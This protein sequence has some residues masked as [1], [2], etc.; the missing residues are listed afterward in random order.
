MN[1]IALMCVRAITP[2]WL[3]VVSAQAQPF[4][5]APAFQPTTS[6]VLGWTNEG[7][8][9]AIAHANPQAPHCYRDGL[10]MVATK[11]TRD[12]GIP[13]L[14]GTERQSDITYRCPK[15]GQTARLQR[16]NWVTEAVSSLL[17]SN[18]PV[19]KPRPVVPAVAPKVGSIRP[20]L[21]KPEAATIQRT[22]R[23]S[24]KAI[25]PPPPPPQPPDAPPIPPD[26]PAPAS[27]TNA[28]FSLTWLTFDPFTNTT[29][30]R[31]YV[32]PI[33][34]TRYLVEP[35]Q[36]YG[37][38][39]GLSYVDVAGVSVATNFAT[40]T[41]RLKIPGLLYGQLYWIQAQTV[42]GTNLSDLSIALAWPQTR[43]NGDVITV[44]KSY[45]LT[46][47]SAV[48]S[49]TVVVQ[50]DPAQAYFYRVQGIRTNNID[51]FQVRE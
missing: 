4:T 30:F 47:W 43:T 46:N 28:T 15:C 2:L 14:G 19:R 34:S 40:S 20:S 37:T 50:N 10:V 45:N 21:R 26:A 24:E 16:T 1:F 9:Q 6:P 35:G 44:A 25:T 7:F 29:N 51:P 48:P 39:I 12:L 31:V 23:Y 17:V 42:A 11:T 22:N 36:F 18:A 3:T 5:P 41:N 27:G 32:T 38:T 49:A 13:R 8:I 33:A